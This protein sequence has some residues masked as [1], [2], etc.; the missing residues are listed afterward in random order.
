MNETNPII[1]DEP[2]EEGVEQQQQAAVETSEPQETTIDLDDLVKAGVL[3]VEGSI[4][5]VDD[6]VSAIEKAQKTYAEQQLEQFFSSLP[7]DVAYAVQYALTTGGNLSDFYRLY[8]SMPTPPTDEQSKKQ[9]VAQYLQATTNFS[10]NKIEKVIEALEDDELEEEAQKAYEAL[11]NSQK[12]YVEQ[13]RE[14]R[15]Q[16]QQQMAQYYRQQLESIKQ[17]IET[18]SYH[19][20][21]KQKLERFIFEPKKTAEGVKTHFQL[22]LEQIASKPQH[23]IELADILTNYSSD[24]GFDLSSWERKAQSN[25]VARIKGSLPKEQAPKSSKTNSQPTDFFENWLSNL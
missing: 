18:S 23:L 14:E 21:K 1:N 17:A 5:S 9:V 4:S 16:R 20:H 8:A 19:P 7:D 12:A 3:P 22:V 10:P 11:V 13:L 24:R 15:L 25:V 6:I 2:I